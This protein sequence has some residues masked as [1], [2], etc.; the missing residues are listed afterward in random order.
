MG[1]KRKRPHRGAELQL[2]EARAALAHWMQTARILVGMAGGSVLV[3]LAEY[4]K[5][6]DA[7]LKIVHR[8][9]PVTGDTGDLIFTLVAPEPVPDIT[10]EDEGELIAMLDAKAARTKAWM[11][12][13]EAP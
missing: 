13:E 6:H 1:G 8:T 12:G 2:A 4:E 10:P 9:D 11:D 3:T 5:W 7:D